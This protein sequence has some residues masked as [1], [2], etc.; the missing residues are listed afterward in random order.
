MSSYL[1]FFFRVALTS[2][3]KQPTQS[4]TGSRPK[5]LHL[6]VSLPGWGSERGPWEGDR[7]SGISGLGPS[8]T[9]LGLP[10]KESWGGV[11]KELRPL[12]I[13]CLPKCCRGGFLGRLVCRSKACTSGSIKER[14]E[15]LE[16]Q[17]ED[18]TSGRSW[19]LVKS[20]TYTWR[21]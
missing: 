9:G 16:G 3:E 13:S 21:H 17:L 1:S 2:W 11:G 10:P 18:S 12:G 8:P 7:V 20:R 5:Y 19:F 14:W 15:R 4:H 6:W